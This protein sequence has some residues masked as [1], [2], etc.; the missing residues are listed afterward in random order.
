MQRAQCQLTKRVSGVSRPAPERAG[1]YAMHLDPRNT[2]DKGIGSCVAQ[3]MDLAAA[4]EE[5]VGQRLGGEQMSAGAAGG[6][7]KGHGHR[8]L[9][10]SRR[11]VSAS[12]I[13]IPRPSA[14]NEDPP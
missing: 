1:A 6:E 9:P 13:P 11:R 3:K 4:A 14:S 8:P 5:L 7:H 10:S 2:P 12:I